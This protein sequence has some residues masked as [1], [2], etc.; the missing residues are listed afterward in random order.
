MYNL[1]IVDDEPLIREGLK[2]ALE[3]EGFC[4]EVASNGTEALELMESFKP[5]LVITDII[6]PEKDGI[7]IIW[8]LREKYPDIKIIAISGGGRISATDHLKIAKK[9]G[10]NT[11]LTKPFSTE[12]LLHEI[13]KI[14]N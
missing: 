13:S 4:T 11:I 14:L 9:L 2:Q 6:M 8:T 12:D 3:M 1:L 10:A 7:E 5:H